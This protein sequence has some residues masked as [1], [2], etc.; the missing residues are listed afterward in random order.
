MG[1]YSNRDWWGRAHMRRARKPEGGTELV[2][3]IAHPDPEAAQGQVESLAANFPV[4]KDGQP[5]RYAAYS[6]RWGEDPKTG[7]TAPVHWHVGQDR[8]GEGES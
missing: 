3:K 7:Q 2:P 6:C 5:R 1:R 4:A 8:R